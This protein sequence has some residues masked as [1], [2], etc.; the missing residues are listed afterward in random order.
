M[1]DGKRVWF[2]T[3]TDDPEETALTDEER[4]ERAWQS[5]LAEDTRIDVRTD[6]EFDAEER[7]FKAGY[8]AALKEK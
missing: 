3:L 8:L 1:S 5:R 7:G 4:A 6:D 2:V